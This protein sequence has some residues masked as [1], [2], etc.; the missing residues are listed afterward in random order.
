[1]C[2][3]CA[4]TV[5]NT[6]KATQEDAALMSLYF[7]HAAAFLAINT[8]NGRGKFAIAGRV[9]QHLTLADIPERNIRPG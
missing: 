7:A 8:E 3:C 4:C 5:A 9:I 2:T 6:H 1:M